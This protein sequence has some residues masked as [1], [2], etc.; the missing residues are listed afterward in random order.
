VTYIVRKI[1]LI[2]ND[3]MH[4]ASMAQWE[5]TA[6]RVIN[7]ESLAANLRFNI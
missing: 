7:C 3:V 2:K 5:H 4:T 1:D 6:G